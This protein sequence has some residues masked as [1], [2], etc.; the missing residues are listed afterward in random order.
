MGTTTMGTTTRRPRRR[1]SEE[2][3]RRPDSYYASSYNES[4]MGTFVRGTRDERATTWGLRGFVPPKKFRVDAYAYAHCEES[5]GERVETRMNGGWMSRRSVD[6]TREMTTGEEGTGRRRR[7]RRARG[8]GRGETRGGDAEE[9]GG[10]DDESTEL[11]DGDDDESGG[12]LIGDARRVESSRVVWR[13]GRVFERR[14]TVLLRCLCIQILSF[15]HSSTNALPSSLAVF[16]ARSIT[17]RPRR[18]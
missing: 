18:R 16:D 15:F 9:T 14:E 1:A 2:T 6:G 11:G 3:E 8:G 5:D 4:P 12:V 10:R 17:R 13:L 7:R